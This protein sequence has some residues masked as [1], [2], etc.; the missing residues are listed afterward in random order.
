M[1]GGPVVVDETTA[2][3][4]RYRLLTLIPLIIFLGLG[5]HFLLPR[6]GA[7]EDSFELIHRMSWPL[8]LL[9]LAAQSLSYIANGGLLCIIVSLAGGHLG[10][11]RATAIVTAASTVALVAGGVVGYAAAIH[12]WTRG[13]GVKRNASMLAVTITPVFDGAALLLF[14]LA[15]AVALLL[16]SR[17]TPS[18]ERAL[19]IVLAAIV[20]MIGAGAY[21]LA[22]PVR[23]ASLLR[24][25]RFLRT[26]SRRFIETARTVSKNVRKGAAAEAGFAAL[27][28]LVFDILTLEVVFIAAGHPVDPLT[29]I[30]GYGVPL[31]LGRFSFLPGGI[32]VVEV[33]MIATYVSLGLS[34]AVVIVAILTYR[35]ISFWIPTLIGIPIA[36]TLQATSRSR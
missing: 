17:L 1:S 2:M 19:A 22:A 21:A 10:V 11:R 12:R 3:P 34:A 5:I 30:A 36:V 31:L 35:L 27:L 16:R 7:I 18:T 28:N 20:V 13:R 33:G 8:L 6:L 9:A 25:I 29:L 32:A 4:R 26:R 23:V 15:S 14:A 24:R